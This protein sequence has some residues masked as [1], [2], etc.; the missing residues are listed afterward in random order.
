LVEVPGSRKRC[1]ESTILG[2][3]GFVPELK[4]VGGSVEAEFDGVVAVD[5]ELF[6]GEVYCW[7]VFS[8]LGM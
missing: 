5:V 1:P 7:G 4:R 6:K 8:R 3:D 2:V